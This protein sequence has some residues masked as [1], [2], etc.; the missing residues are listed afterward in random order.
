MPEPTEETHIGPAAA[1]C[2]TGS[3]AVPSAG[4]SEMP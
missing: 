4:S 3:D 2:C 1:A